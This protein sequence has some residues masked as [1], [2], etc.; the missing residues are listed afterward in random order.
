MFPGSILLWR[1]NTEVPAKKP[2][3]FRGGHDSMTPR[4]RGSR[5]RTGRRWRNSLPITWSISGALWQKAW[6]K[7]KA[8]RPH[9]PGRPGFFLCHELVSCQ[10]NLQ[11]IQKHLFAAAFDTKATLEGALLGLM[12]P[13][14]MART[15]LT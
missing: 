6:V 3:G 2:R 12:V 8:L 5:P 1:R 10:S 9:Q 11:K 15:Y 4:L 13:W 14:F 7:A